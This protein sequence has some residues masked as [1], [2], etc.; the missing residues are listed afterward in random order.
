MDCTG[1]SQLLLHLG[2]KSSII[3]RFFCSSLLASWSFSLLQTTEVNIVS[4]IV[5]LCLK[6]ALSHTENLQR[7][8]ISKGM[9]GVFSCRAEQSDNITTEIFVR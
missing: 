4:S 6:W 8:I 3:A 9:L 1:N 7:E 2:S 5:L